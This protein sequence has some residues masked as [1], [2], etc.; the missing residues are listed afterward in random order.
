MRFLLVETDDFL[1]TEDDFHLIVEPM[2]QYILDLENGNFP[3]QSFLH[4][5]VTTSGFHYPVTTS[6]LQ[7]ERSE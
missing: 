5:P 2:F 4:Y 1:N 7:Y 3:T 6:E